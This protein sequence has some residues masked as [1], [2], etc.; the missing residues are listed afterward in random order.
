MNRTEGNGLKATPVIEPLIAED[1][2]KSS[3]TAE[4]A[5]NGGVK[6]PYVPGKGKPKASLKDNARVLVLGGGIAIVL[7]W[8]ALSG[9]PRN[10]LTANKKPPQA[11]SSR[12]RSLLRMA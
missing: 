5:Q 8:L 7:L 11:G 3:H 1:L 6:Q 12:S 9:I 2:T 4:V 10:Q